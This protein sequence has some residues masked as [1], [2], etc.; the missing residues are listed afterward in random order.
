MASQLVAVK[1]TLSIRNKPILI[2]S[3]Q[4]EYKHKRS[5]VNDRNSWECRK[6]DGEKCKAAATTILKDGVEYIEKFYETIVGSIT[7]ILYNKTNLKEFIFGIR[8]M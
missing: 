2:D 1:F 3:N 6:K 8:E 4:L 7:S 5:P